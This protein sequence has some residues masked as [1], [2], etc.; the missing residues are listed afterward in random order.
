MCTEDALLAAVRT[1]PDDDLPRL[2]YADWLDENGDADRAEYI[3]CQIAAVRWGASSPEA[4]AA[5]ERAKRLLDANGERW[6]VP[7]A[8]LLGPN[9]YLYDFHR[10]FVE[11]LLL[12]GYDQWTAPGLPEFLRSPFVAITS[13]GVFTKQDSPLHSPDMVFDM[14]DH[15]QFE[16]LRALHFNELAVHAGAMEMIVAHP[17][18]NGL[19]LLGFWKCDL[20]DF[21]VR[22]LADTLS[23]PRVTTLWL[24]FSRYGD[25]DVVAL[26]RSPWL[27]QLVDLSL[28]GNPTLTDVSARALA[29]SPHLGQLTSLDVR[30]C[31]ALTDDG[32]AAL[33]ARFGERV[34]V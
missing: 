20:T 14:F 1:A 8:G 23:L 2:V 3:R 6:R 26:A 21:V 12:S 11:T 27:N 9:S 29:D 32:R 31:S 4:A 28:R 15:P 13:V 18:L 30:W 10:G 19:E 25:P 7:L 5:H 17:R 22:E 24:S 34:M 33:R 16:C